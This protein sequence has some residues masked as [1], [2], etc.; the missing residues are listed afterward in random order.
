[1]SG[2]Y[3][4][5]LIA[6]MVLIYGLVSVH[7]AHKKVLSAKHA[8]DY[9]TYH[10]AIAEAVDGGDPYDTKA[11]SK[12]ARE[13]K[14]RKSV[15]PYFYPPPFLLGMGWAAP[16]DLSLAY[17]VFFWLSQLSILGV[18]II[19]RRWIGTPLI[20]LG[21][22]ACTL[23]PIT[24]SAKMGQANALVLLLAV[25]GLWRMSGGLI[26]AAAMAKMSPALYLF[27]WAARQSWRPVLIACATA[28]AL[29]LLSL[30][31]VGPEAQWRFYTEVL[32]GFSSGHYHGLTVK[33]ALPANHSIPDLFNQYWPG[34]DK[35]TLS[36]M[37]QTGSKIT[38]VCALAALVWLA[39][40][41]RDTLGDANLYA[42]FSVLMLIAPVYTY[43]HHLVAALFPAA[44]L[45]TALVRRRLGP[46]AWFLALPAYFFVAW[47]LYWLRPL[48]KMAPELKWQL[49]ES[50][51]FGLV[52]LGLLCA[53]VAWRSPRV[54]TGPSTGTASSRS[55]RP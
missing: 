11:L 34:P 5:A 44:A 25:A 53:W 29:S 3:R 30:V 42:A 7:P 14:T 51:F 13:D 22:L 33:I 54:E 50:K 37:A 35:H 4:W 15:H 45:G 41:K 28:V 48:Q 6:V 17:Q 12:R 32:P 49:Q 2:R 8:R 46:W 31:L 40:H 16:L 52:V 10:Y 9:A 18:L 26:G 23:T 19:L 24:D 55:P 21:V 43:E 47:P 1:M 39:R 38:T 36:A 20:V 27:A